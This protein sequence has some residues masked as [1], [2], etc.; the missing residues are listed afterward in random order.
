[1][2][3]RWKKVT[4]TIRNTS[5]QPVE[6]ARVRVSGAGVKIATKQTNVS[7]KVTFRIRAKKYPGRVAFKV[8][9]TG[10]TTTTYYRSVRLS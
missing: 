4:L 1:V 10:F 7:G 5:F 3:N 9:K 6:A 8:T 2:R